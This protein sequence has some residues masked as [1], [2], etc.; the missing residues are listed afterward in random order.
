M[1]ADKIVEL[2]DAIGV[3]LTKTYL[4]PAFTVNKKFLFQFFYRYF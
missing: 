1:V 4:V 2:Q 3:D